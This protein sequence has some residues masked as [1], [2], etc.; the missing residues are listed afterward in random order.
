[1]WLMSHIIVREPRRSICLE[2]ATMLGPSAGS[3]LA[4]SAMQWP[5]LAMG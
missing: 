4:L 3:I 2:T 1:M 5:S